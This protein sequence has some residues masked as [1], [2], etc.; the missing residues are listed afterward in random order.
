MESE[1]L[2]T[3]ADARRLFLLGLLG[4]FLEL[5]L[6]RYLAGNIW[7]LGYFPNLVLIAVFTG[8]GIGF[9]FHERVADRYSPWAFHGALG[10]LVVLAAF[11][12][13]ASPAVPGFEKAGG[14][15]AGE[16][17]FTATSAE[18]DVSGRL[19]EMPGSQD[20]LQRVRCR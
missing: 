9:V 11:V 14:E 4:L 6:I 5:T 18:S 8:M 20:T 10:L 7:N 12:T 16:L 13:F 15:V 19:S 17:F 1:P 2:P 3:G